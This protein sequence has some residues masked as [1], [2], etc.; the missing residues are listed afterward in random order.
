MQV[1]YILQH[2]VA[3]GRDWDEQETRHLEFDSADTVLAGGVVCP[4]FTPEE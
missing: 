4:E 1:K 2:M 3:K